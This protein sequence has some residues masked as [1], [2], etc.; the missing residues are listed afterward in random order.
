MA[1]SGLWGRLRAGLQKTRQALKE[2]LD[3]VL[4]RPQLD[5]ATLEDLEEALIMADLGVQAT[6]KVLQ[7]VRNRVKDQK[8]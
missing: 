6:E 1:E 4:R 2:N 8:R 7:E 5:E 3:A